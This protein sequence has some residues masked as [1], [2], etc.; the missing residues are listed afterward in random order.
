MIWASRVDDCT[1]LRLSEIRQ[2]AC[3]RFRPGLLDLS[4]DLASSVLIPRLVTTLGPL[5]FEK[6]YWNFAGRLKFDDP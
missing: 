6:A 2:E 4:L 5:E 1:I 3:S